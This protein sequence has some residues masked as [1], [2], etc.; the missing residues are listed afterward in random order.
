MG[1][2]T[3]RPGVTRCFLELPRDS[4]TTATNQRGEIDVCALS[5]GVYSS[6]QWVVEIP[7]AQVRRRLS[8]PLSCEDKRDA[9][10]S[11]LAL[12]AA[13]VRAFSCLS[14]PALRRALTRGV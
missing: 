3:A 2:S 1:R 8:L 7:V 10:K 11:A 14:V 6:A 5:R 13:R 9:D 12:I 4:I